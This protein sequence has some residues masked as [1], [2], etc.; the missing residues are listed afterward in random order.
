VKESVHFEW[1]DKSTYIH[2][3]PFFKSVQK[4]L[5]Q[6]Q[7]I[8]DAYS[9]AVFGD[10][11]TTDHI[12]PAGNISGTSPAARFLKERG[13]E[14][15]DFNT[16][17]SRRGN[18][19][20]MARGT[21]ANIRVLNKMMKGKVGPQTVHVPSGEVLDIFDAAER[22]IKE[23]HQTVIFG[24]KEYGAGSSRD[25][26]AKGPFLL[27]VKAVI[28]ESFERI[29]RSNLIGMGI[30]P[31]NFINGESVSTLGIDGS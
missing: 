3:P 4:E 28:T 13:I 17:G 30:F 5:S 24:G 27:G 12:S 21:F 25:W 23:G 6:L 11:I 18:D 22:Y 7:P 29:H 1:S 2:D 20:I 15:R 19:L 9:L 10:S 8:K 31:L 14:K 26:A 16:Y